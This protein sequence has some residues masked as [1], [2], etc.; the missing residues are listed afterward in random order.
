M[1][2]VLLIDFSKYSSNFD[3]GAGRGTVVLAFS[4][5]AVA[6]LLA[7]A[8]VAPVVIQVVLFSSN[9]YATGTKV[10]LALPSSR[11]W[12]GDPMADRGR[13]PRGLTRNPACGWAGQAGVRRDDSRDAAY[14]GYEAYSNRVES[15]GRRRGT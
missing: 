12:D 7:V 13:R 8:C 10:A 15:L 9:L 4:M 3:A 11:P 2:D 6:A 1:F 5:G 14:Y